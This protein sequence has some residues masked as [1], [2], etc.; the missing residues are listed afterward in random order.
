MWLLRGPS[1]LTNH[2]SG[3]TN[4]NRCHGFITA[5][6]SA[7]GADLR[8]GGMVSALVGAVGEAQAAA[9]LRALPDPDGVEAAIA[10]DEDRH[11]ALSRDLVAWCAA[12]E[13][14]ARVAVRALERAA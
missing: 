9:D 5:R 6:V 8:Y 3:S 14:R 10:A 2:A 4:P 11:A 13:P 12:E 7:D 1:P